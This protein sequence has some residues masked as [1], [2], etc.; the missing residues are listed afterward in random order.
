[1][2]LR[3]LLLLATAAGGGLLIKY[4]Y[5]QDQY[6]RKLDQSLRNNAEHLKASTSTLAKLE[7]LVRARTQEDHDACD[8]LSRQSSVTDSLPLRINEGCSGAAEGSNVSYDHASAAVMATT[9]IEDSLKVLRQAG[10]DKHNLAAWRADERLRAA[11]IAALQPVRT[12]WV[13]GVFDLTHYGHMFMFLLAR[14]LGTRLVVGVNS[15]SSVRTAKGSVP[16]VSEADRITMVRAIKWVDDV[17]ENVPY[18]MDASYLDDMVRKHD[19]HHI[20]HGNDPCLDADGNDVYASAKERGLYSSIPRVTGI[21]TT[22]LIGRMLSYIRY[23]AE[24]DDESRAMLMSKVSNQLKYEK[25][26]QRMRM[27]GTAR[28]QFAATGEI[29]AKFLHAS[30]RTRKQ[31]QPLVYIDGAFDLLHAGHVRTLQMV[32][33]EA[34]KAFGQE[35]FLVVG[36]HSDYEI[37]SRWSGRPILNLHERVL[38]VM[39]LKPVDDVV[40]DSPCVIHAIH[41]QKSVRCGIM[42]AGLCIRS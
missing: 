28:W 36:I 21:S 17:E 7:G 2:D 4:L 30:Q 8:S 42:K 19:L 39:A 6:L 38:S 5:Q 35:P 31:G 23:Q 14:N 37:G 15:D 27:S 22:E 18:I 1:M 24:P 11:F 32:R 34:T 9:T 16:L 26:G 20:C 29:Y 40:M 25:N 41:L 10:V 13:D 12:C 33:L 3:P